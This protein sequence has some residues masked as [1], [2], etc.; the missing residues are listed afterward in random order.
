MAN[1][2]QPSPQARYIVETMF[3]SEKNLLEAV[4]KLT[5]KINAQDK[6]LTT[7]G[8]VF[9]KVQSQV[10]LSLKSI[11]ALQQEQILLVKSV[12]VQRAGGLPGS[13]DDCGVMGSSPQS[14]TLSGQPA[15]PPPN[16]VHHHQVN[17]TNSPV[18]VLG[19]F[20]TSP[21]IEGSKN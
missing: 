6:R 10:D 14:A 7:L 19:S 18:N 5:E 21:D 16:Q 1:P 8:S 3:E 2:Y 4:H 20:R 17:S 15:P 13:L 9:S 12:R 11:Q